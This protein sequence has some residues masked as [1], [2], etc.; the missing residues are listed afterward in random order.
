[1]VTILLI[2]VNTNQLILQLHLEEPLNEYEYTVL[3]DAFAIF[4]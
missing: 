4:R 2:G 1:M 3:N